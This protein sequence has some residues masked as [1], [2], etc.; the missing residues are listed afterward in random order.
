M[1]RLQRPLMMVLIG[2]LLYG[3]SRK[4][5]H[6]D[7]NTPSTPESPAQV[8]D[9]SHAMDNRELRPSQPPATSVIL[10]DVLASWGAGDKDGAMAQ[11]LSIKWDDA[12]VFR[13]IETFSVSE[14]QFVS[15]SED[16]REPIVQQ[17]RGVASALSLL[18]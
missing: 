6:S 15:L 18:K 13:D 14:Q 4:E 16:Q 9:S 7:T 5:D 17:A 3:Y 8:S 11:F 2:T 1:R 12:T 10:N